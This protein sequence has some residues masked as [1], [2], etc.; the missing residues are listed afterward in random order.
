MPCKSGGLIQRE[1]SS[2]R[3]P[4]NEATRSFRDK[5]HFQE[6][7]NITAKAS[8][9]PEPPE[10]SKTGLWSNDRKQT[11]VKGMRYLISQKTKL[12]LKFRIIFGLKNT[13]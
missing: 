2:R 7:Y 5:D 10:T 12:N 9:E 13:C 1:Q 3:K 6:T 4:E 11:K 8:E